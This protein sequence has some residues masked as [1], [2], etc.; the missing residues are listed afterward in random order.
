MSW[1]E[2]PSRHLANVRRGRDALVLQPG[3]RLNA[4]CSPPDGRAV[5]SARPNRGAIRAKT[6]SDPPPRPA[7]PIASPCRIYLP[8]GITHKPGCNTKPRPLWNRWFPLLAKNSA[9]P[10]WRSSSE[11]GFFRS[12]LR[13]D[14]QR[15]G[16]TVA[17][18]RHLA[19]SAAH[20][21]SRERFL[22]LHEIAA[23]GCATAVAERTGRRAQTVMEWLHAYNEHGPEALTYQRTGGRPPFVQSARDERHHVVYLDEAHIYQDVD[24]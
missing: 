24:L 14:H 21:R 13:V 5:G 7:H 15:W 20:P 8:A 3:F 22:A 4:L 23:G 12:V 16:Q 9:V 10:I 19:L 6:C 18:L 2:R 11:Q 17:D 1:C